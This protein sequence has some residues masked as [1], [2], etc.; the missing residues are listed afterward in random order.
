MS[1][2]TAIYT[3]Q[4]LSA[5]AEFGLA[6]TKTDISTLNYN[7]LC[8]TAT[9]TSSTTPPFPGREIT[10]YAAISDVNLNVATP[11]LVQSQLMPVAN[12]FLIKSN[13]MVSGVSTYMSKALP[14]T[15]NYLY[16][17]ISHDTLGN[18]VS[19]NVGYIPNNDASGGGGDVNIGAIIQ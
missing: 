5:D 3:S 11:G 16:T 7:G 15:A 19:L 6:P 4:A 18:A 9:V 14:L 17:W 2:A 12:R 10:V 8:L 13:G 1:T